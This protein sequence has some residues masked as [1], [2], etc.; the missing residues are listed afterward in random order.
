MTVQVHL[1]RLWVLTMVLA[2]GLMVLF[3]VVF[4]QSHQLRFAGMPRM[5]LMI[6]DNMMGNGEAEFFKHR[7]PVRNDLQEYRDPAGAFSFLH[8]TGTVATFATSTVA[9]QLETRVTLF[10]AP[11]ETTPVPDM[12]VRI[13]GSSV[14]FDTHE[15]MEIPYFE[16]VV[17]SFHF[18][19]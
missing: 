3:V 9:G 5:K 14:H 11:L 16:E 8:P 4:N 2:V 1:H 10:G 7:V 6:A 13:Q 19:K 17:S 18:T 12:T 15:G